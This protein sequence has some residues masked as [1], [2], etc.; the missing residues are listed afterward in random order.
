MC[1]LLEPDVSFLERVGIWIK[2]WGKAGCT[3]WSIAQVFL[4]TTNSHFQWQPRETSWLENASYC[5]ANNLYGLQLGGHIELTS[6]GIWHGQQELTPYS[7]DRCLGIFNYHF[8]DMKNLSLRFR[9]KDSS[10]YCCLCIDAVTPSVH[11]S[12]DF[13]TLSTGKTAPFWPTST[14]SVTRDFP[15]GLLCIY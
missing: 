15:G 13:S 12:I 9:P 1:I 7:F 3:V 10:S 11:W 6:L 14:I 4:L 5:I 8:K 2:A